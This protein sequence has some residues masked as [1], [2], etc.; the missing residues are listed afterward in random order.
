L[1][2]EGS[3]AS[4]ANQAEV[5]AVKINTTA[6]TVHWR[7]GNAWSDHSVSL[8]P[9]WT[10]TDG[11]GMSATLDAPV[12]SEGSVGG[13]AF[14]T[15]LLRLADDRSLIVHTVVEFRSGIPSGGRQELWQRFL[16][17]GAGSP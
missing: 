15:Y 16:R 8:L 7:Y 4:P 17:E 13:H 3:G 12:D 2:V 10:C 11:T 1:F 9:R 6:M 5:S 14:T